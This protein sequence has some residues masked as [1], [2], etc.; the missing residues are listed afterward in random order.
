MSLRT[1]S[2]ASVFTGSAWQPTAFVPP[3]PQIDQTS[4]NGLSGEDGIMVTIEL[5]DELLCVRRSTKQVI[6]ASIEF[7]ELR[8]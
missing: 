2:T 1:H 3:L 4:Q 7:E 8:T 6:D 5:V